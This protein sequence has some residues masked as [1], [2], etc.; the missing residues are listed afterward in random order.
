[1]SSLRNSLHRRNHKERSQLAHRSRL[2]ILEKHKDY[3]LRARDFH[4]KQ[5]RLT[6]LRQKAADRNKDEFYFGMTREQT[7]GGVH[8]QD[9]GNASLPVDIVKVLKSQ[10]ENYIR[11]KR[12]A[13]LK[14]IDKL[15]NQLTALADLVKPLDEDEDEDALDE[16]ELE[17]LR[18]AGILPKAAPLKKRRK[19]RQTRTKHV[20][21]AE[22]EDEAREY[23]EPPRAGA[24]EPE[25]KMEVE[26]ETIDL[27]WKVN[28]EVPKKRKG[29]E[30][31][32]QTEDVTEPGDS[33]EASELRTRLLK[34]LSARLARDK[35]LR[36][37]ER[38]LEMQRLLMGKGGSR[39]LRGVEKVEEDGD[40]E[41]GESDEDRRPKK[42][43]EKTWKPRVYKW[44]LERKR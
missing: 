37:A 16:A 28:G 42:V 22:N 44:K 12:T 14:K 15:K 25:D 13:G 20:V 26:E 1:M 40:S 21:F 19:A 38:E 18:E 10:D 6:R 29:K 41:E 34:E 8:I 33:K 36:Y 30:R 24:S 43:D 32:H 4:S 23:L 5:D 7:R 11:T 39:K 2:G 27:G 35:Q 3:V 17:V 9:R 31:A